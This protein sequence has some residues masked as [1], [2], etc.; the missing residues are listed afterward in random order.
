MKN[1]ELKFRK[2]DVLIPL[3]AI[4][5]S[6]GIWIFSAFSPGADGRGD[7]VRVTVNGEEYGRF[8]LSEK[9]DIIIKGYA[10]YTNTLVIDNG[11][12]DITEA[13]CPD[14]ICVHQR[15]IS[16]SGETIVCLPNRV[17]I[18]IEG[19]EEGNIDAVSR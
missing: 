11:E 5:F 17:V 4:I 1:E 7:T 3:A 16:R 18:G 15:K 2:S 10:G 13:G 6:A 9:R 19:K 14:K 8:P 12:A